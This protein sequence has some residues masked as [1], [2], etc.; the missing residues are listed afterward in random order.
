MAAF[1]WRSCRAQVVVMFLRASQM[2]LVA[3]ASLG[4]W[5]RVLMILRSL[6]LTL[7]MALV[8]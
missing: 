7:S 2:S 1:Q 4:K 8:V 5:P 6:A 3:A